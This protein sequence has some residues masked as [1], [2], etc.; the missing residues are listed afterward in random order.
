MSTPTSGVGFVN[1][2][3]TAWNADFTGSSS[4]S[5]NN[6]L[7]LDNQVWM[8]NTIANANNSH[9][10]IKTI[11]AGT[12][13]NFIAT[14]TTFTIN[15]TGDISGPGVSTDKAIVRWN[16]ATG[17][18]INNSSTLITD[19][20]AIQ[21][22][23]GTSLNPGHSYTGD[24]DTGI[25]NNASNQQ[26]VTCGNTDVFSWSA[27]GISSLKLFSFFA[28]F[29]QNYVSPGAYP[30]SVLDGSACTVLVDTSGARTINLPNAPSDG[31]VFIIK[32]FTGTASSFN[33]NVTTPGGVVLIDAAT[34]YA[35]NVNY[36]SAT[37]QWVGTKYV[38]I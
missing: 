33:I 32:D 26:T 27:F 13:I 1:G 11:T 29:C 34:T 14:P 38:V 8:G 7:I 5:I 6:G 4:S 17:T 3:A 28:G 24:T 19:A 9:V 22:T 2:V 12:N 18:V 20:G 23:S 21:S 10:G 31:R 16:G 25:Y 15:A 36:G 35:I 37:F 30:Y